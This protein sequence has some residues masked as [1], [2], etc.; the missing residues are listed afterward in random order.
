MLVWESFTEG[1]T[2]ELRSRGWARDNWP[3]QKVEQK[4]SIFRAHRESQTILLIEFG[5]ILSDEVVEN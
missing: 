5:C 1:E 3:A 4:V 2:L